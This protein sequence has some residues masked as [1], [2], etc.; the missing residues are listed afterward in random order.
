MGL[1]VRYLLDSHIFLWFDDPQQLSPSVREALDDENN[2]L[3]LS[4]A[5]IWELTLKRALGKLHFTG[6]FAVAAAAYQIGVVPVRAEHV[7]ATESLP[8]LHKDPLDH[9]LLAQARVED[10][11]LVTHDAVLARYGVPVWLV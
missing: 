4:V 9:L 5:S 7:E 2:Q 10:L 1:L 8:R 6:P 3:Y 11:V